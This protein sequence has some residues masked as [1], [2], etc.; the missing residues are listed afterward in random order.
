MRARAHT[1]THTHIRARTHTHIRTPHTPYRHTH[2]HTRMHHCTCTI[3]QN[4]FQK[5]KTARFHGLLSHLKAKNAPI[6]VTD[7]FFVMGGGAYCFSNTF[8]FQRKTRTA[9]R[10]CFFFCV[11][12]YIFLYIHIHKY[13]YIYLHRM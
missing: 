4:K 7:R 10:S 9:L 8:F 11:C 3:P 6:E 1:H 12:T 2:T 13:F 5:K